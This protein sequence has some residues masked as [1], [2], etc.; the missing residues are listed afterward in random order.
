MNQL[1]LFDDTTF[2]D[3]PMPE[4][5]AAAYRFPLQSHEVDGVTVYAVQ[6]WIRGVADMQDVRGLTTQMR[7][8]AAELFTSCQQ[9]PYK[10]TNGRTYQMDYIDAEGLYAITQRLDTNTGLRNKVLAY[11]AKAGVKLDE[12]RRDPALMIAEGVSHLDRKAKRLGWS[13]EHKAARRESADTRVLMTDAIKDAVSAVLTGRDY[14]RVTDTEYRELY[15]RSTR[16]LRTALG[17]ADGANLR[18]YQPRTALAYQRAAEQIIADMAHGRVGM[19][20]DECLDLVARVCRMIGRQIRE[21][22]GML[23]IDIATGMPLLTGSR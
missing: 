10:A 2:D 16:E 9:L 15:G 18:D 5:I 19:T 1:A 3:A 12:Y 7:R 11:L 6:D 22:S 4:R 14:A 17:L 21:S 23:G 13:D 8:R 20:L